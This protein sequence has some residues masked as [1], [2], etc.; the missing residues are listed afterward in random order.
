MAESKTTMEI[1]RLKFEELVAQVRA[2]EPCLG[3]G[4]SCLEE[5]NVM[6]QAGLTAMRERELVYSEGHLSQAEF[7]EMSV[8][9]QLALVTFL[10]IFRKLFAVKTGK[11]LQA[12][13]GAHPHACSSMWN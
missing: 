1:E 2:L 9:S 6:L 11:E 3:C 7:L 8:R 4:G 13:R 12:M 5:R 10:E